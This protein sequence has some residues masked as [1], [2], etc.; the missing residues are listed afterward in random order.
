[1][2]SAIT[3]IFETPIYQSNI[4]REFTDEEGY[5]FSHHLDLM[6]MKNESN[7]I[8]INRYILDTPELK[9]LKAIIENK[10]NDFFK[11]IYSPADAVSLVITQSWLNLTKKG[12]SH[13]KHRHANSFISGVLYLKSSKTLDKIIFHKD[14]YEQL[15]I[16]PTE[17]TSYNCRDVGF[18]VE[19]GDLILFPSSL[20]HSVLPI[21]TDYRISLAFNSFIKGQLG[22]NV[23]LT[24]LVL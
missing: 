18:S 22:D 3:G 13:R 10:L 23:S 15:L 5:I 12:E 24:E 20:I 17:V 14:N 1:M 11:K 9:D 4:D 6:M 2:T 21:E 8:S 19:T 16:S 7:A